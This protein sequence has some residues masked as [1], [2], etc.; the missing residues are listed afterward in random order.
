MI[1]LDNSYRVHV[2][3]MVDEYAKQCGVKK[4]IVVKFSTRL[5]RWLG[6][7][8]YKDST[9]VLNDWFIRNN[10]FNKPALD[11]LLIHEIL[12]FK[13]PRHTKAF[14]E[15]CEQMGI[16]GKD[17]VPGTRHMPVC[18]YVCNRCNATKSFYIRQHRRKCK[19]GG[20]LKYVER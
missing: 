4:T 6:M 8:L 2:V 9:L 20:S 10:L 18:E 19:C 1:T 13:Y 11:N 7:C 17:C 15:A 14:Y 16:D 5:K 12:H 3:S